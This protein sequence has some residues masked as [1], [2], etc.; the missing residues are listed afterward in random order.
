MAR[1]TI[2]SGTIFYDYPAGFD[3]VRERTVT[4]VR[5]QRIMGRMGSYVRSYGNPIGQKEVTIF[6]R[7]Y[8][9][10]AT[11]LNDKMEELARV[12]SFGT[13][14]QLTDNTLSRHAEAWLSGFQYTDQRHAFIREVTINLI[15][16]RG[17]WGV[18]DA[19][20]PSVTTVS[21]NSTK[22]IRYAHPLYAGSV[23]GPAQLVLTPSSS[24]WPT[25]GDG[26]VIW[27]GRNLVV[28][29][30][31]EE[32][33]GAKPDSWD[34]LGGGNDPDIIE[35]FGRSGARCLKISKPGGTNHSLSQD[36]NCDASTQYTY[37][38][39]VALPDG[40]TGNV[41]MLIQSRDSGDAFLSNTT[42]NFAVTSPH[43]TRVDVTHTSHASAVLLRCIFRCVNTGEEVYV[44]DVQLERAGVVGEFINTSEPRY[45]HVTFKLESPAQLTQATTDSLAIDCV[46]GRTRL[47]RSGS[48][49]E[50]NDQVNGHYFE[51]VPGL[52]HIEFTEP[53][54]GN[55]DVEIRHRDL[56]L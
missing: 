22:T 45:K 39:Y 5:G 21:I 18:D 54:A 48:W 38:A 30:S 13:A 41:T 40:A 9:T 2:D 23:P 25:S 8:G 53:T 49:Q 47:L 14:M 43:W 4:A 55:L 17:V 16:P 26:E 31:F 3:I 33:V 15:F 1:L 46:R 56:F 10:D 34:T 12:H 36:V 11:D 6:G 44:D 28:N 37:S 32:G 29:S 51:L 19:L 7:L 50:N 27:R 35:W 20:I 42:Q 52:N 24:T